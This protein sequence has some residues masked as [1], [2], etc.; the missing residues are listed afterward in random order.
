MM[1]LAY[2]WS[3]VKWSSRWGI[4]GCRKTKWFLHYMSRFHRHLRSPTTNVSTRF[5][6]LQG[7]CDK[8]GN[9]FLISTYCRL[10]NIFV[11]LCFT[12]TTPCTPA[13][14]CNLKRF[15]LD[16]LSLLEHIELMIALTRERIVST[17]VAIELIVAINEKIFHRPICV[18]KF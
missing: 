15:A 1:K 18:N 6:W 9:I 3:I 16:T 7:G 4:R 12:I 10:Y 17:Q 8:K 5:V 14:L 11:S 2:T 13:I